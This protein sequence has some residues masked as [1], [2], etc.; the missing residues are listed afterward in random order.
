M[1]IARYFTKENV[2]PYHSFEFRKTVSEI[3]NPDG[4]IVFRA[5]DIEVPS[6]WSQV[7][8]DILAQKYFR[9]AGVPACLKPVEE[10]GDRSALCIWPGVTM[11]GD[12]YF[13]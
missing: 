2:S 3:K 11:V 4:S 9:K 8:C 12:L 13:C 1:R 7:A 10:E 5:D 6:H